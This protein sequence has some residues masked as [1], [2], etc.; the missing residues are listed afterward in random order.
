MILTISNKIIG[1][2]KHLVF[3]G[4]TWTWS[5]SI[6]KKSFL[7]GFDNPRDLRG[8]ADALGISVPLFETSPWGKAQKYLK[9]SSIQP[10]WIDC[11]P[12]KAWQAIV[13]EAVDQ[14]WRHFSSAD[15]SYYIS[16]H[17]RNREIIE[18]LQKPLIN[19][20]LLQDRI[21]TAKNG[22]RQSLSKFSPINNNECPDF[23]Y[24][25][26]KSI[27]GR[28]TITSGPN[29]LTMKKS[30]RS[31]FKSRYKNGKIIEIDIIS[32]EPRVALSMFGK[33][34]P[35]DVYEDV[36]KKANLKIDRNAAKIATLSALYGASH[37]TLK[38]RI[39][40]ESNSLRVL[41][42]VKGYF[43]VEHIN[44]MIKDQ[45]ELLGYIKNT[46]GRKIL[47]NEPSLNH[48]VQSSAVDVAFDIF[49]ALINKIKSE[50]IDAVP[51]FLIHDA[52]V[53]DLNSNHIEKLRQVCSNGF[54][55]PVTESNF[56]VR[57]KEIK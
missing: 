32:A 42:L 30:D 48:F 56:P 35:G 43:G 7:W 57:I 37:H 38:S 4:S 50:N 8:A 13:K 33:S 23:K 51:L 28:M 22:I 26:S 25:L 47:S 45:Y 54:L 40:K 39:S 36:I 11:V 3:D 19:K 55:S 6:D 9:V 20:L 10:R 2:D 24:S 16:T 44:K 27:T 31:I 1:T 46:H 12:R 34:I 29:I 5:G 53:L 41:D 18:G 21:D 15:N 17:T 49:E 14:L 52:I